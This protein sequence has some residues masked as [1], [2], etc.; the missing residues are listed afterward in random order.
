MARAPPSPNPA[1]PAIACE[2]M[3]SVH[4]VLSA[5]K[6]FDKTIQT[7]TV[8]K[9]DTAV[10]RYERN[11]LDIVD[12]VAIKIYV[13]KTALAALIIRLSKNGSYWQKCYF[14]S[15]QIKTSFFADTMYSSTCYLMHE[16]QS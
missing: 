1:I 9:I 6:L 12:D 11:K 5:L 14:P 15:N 10:L 13:N 7:A 3:Q 16:Q 2:D 8:Y 4:A